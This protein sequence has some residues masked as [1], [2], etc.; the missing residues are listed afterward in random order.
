MWWALFSQ[1]QYV[2]D[3]PDTDEVAFVLSDAYYN[4]KT[5]NEITNSERYLEGFPELEWFDTSASQMFNHLQI[6]AV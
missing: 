3:F 4:A 2:T 1:M 6:M 5:L